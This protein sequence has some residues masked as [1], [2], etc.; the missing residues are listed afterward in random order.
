LL[1]LSRGD[2][3]REALREHLEEEIG[4]EIERDLCPSE[5]TGARATPGD[6]AGPASAA[7]AAAESAARAGAAG[8]PPA[9]HFYQP[10]AGK[11]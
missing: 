10:T 1:S 6:P 9:N 11:Y 7:T 8:G 3:I 2:W 5:G 4:E